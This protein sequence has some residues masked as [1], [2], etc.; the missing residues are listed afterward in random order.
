MTI[1]SQIEDA[2]AVGL[3]HFGRLDLAFNVAGAHRGGPITDMTR[4]ASTA[5]ARPT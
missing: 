1:E 4:E 2:L 5:P 3:E